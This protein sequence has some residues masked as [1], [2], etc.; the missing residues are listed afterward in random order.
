MIRVTCLAKKGKDATIVEDRTWVPD[1]RRKNNLKAGQTAGH[2]EAVAFFPG[3][4]KGAGV[5]PIPRP[6]HC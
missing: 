3:K 5:R 4:E 2:S 6:V 1:Y